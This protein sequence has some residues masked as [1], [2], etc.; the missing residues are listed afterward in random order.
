[1]CA[2]ARYVKFKC[3]VCGDL[4]ISLAAKSRGAGWRVVCR[5]LAQQSFTENTDRSRAAGFA[6]FTTWR[7]A[8]VAADTVPPLTKAQEAAVEAAM[9]AAKEKEAA[10]K[11][12]KKAAKKAGK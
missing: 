5:C 12:A 4:N 9:K 3:E 6:M 10:K 7:E 8:H 1:M 11:V 2:G